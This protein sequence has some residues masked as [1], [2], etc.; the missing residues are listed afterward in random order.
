MLDFALKMLT[1]AQK[2]KFQNVIEVYPNFFDGNEISAYTTKLASIMGCRSNHVKR[3]FELISKRLN[4]RL[5]YELPP[6]DDA[7]H[8]SDRIELEE[9]TKKGGRSRDRLVK[10]RWKT[11]IH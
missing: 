6:L 8:A 5:I 11:F 2:K 7:G 3:N 1:T 9:E 4:G 10:F